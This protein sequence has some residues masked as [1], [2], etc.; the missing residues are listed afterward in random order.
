MA[1]QERHQE[2]E[3]IAE[4]R[5]FRSVPDWDGVSPPESID[6]IAV[7]RMRELLR[8][9]GVDPYTCIVGWWPEGAGSQYGWVVT[10]DRKVFAFDAQDGKG[11]RRT[12]VK[13]RVI[14][15]WEEM[16][17]RVESGASDDVAIALSV[18]ER[19]NSS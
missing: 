6:Q 17:G 14:Y 2:D 5:A 12:Q 13:T 16:T 3:M 10:S 9:K 19:V 15:R 8:E 4:T 18:I 7:T 11:D 1:D